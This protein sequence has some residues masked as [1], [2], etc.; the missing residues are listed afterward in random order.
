MNLI[1][2]NNIQQRKDEEMRLASI[3]EGNYK[4]GDLKNKFQTLIKTDKHVGS[5]EEDGE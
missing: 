5:D 2:E 4:T 3:M 1:I